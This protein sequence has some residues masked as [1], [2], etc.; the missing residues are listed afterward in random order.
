MGSIVECDTLA[1]ARQM[2]RIIELRAA[3][4]LALAPSQAKSDYRSSN[5]GAEAVTRGCPAG[6]DA[7]AV[8][9]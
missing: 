8:R 4:Q 7:V 6:Y 3:S 5:D 2:D 9:A 1:T